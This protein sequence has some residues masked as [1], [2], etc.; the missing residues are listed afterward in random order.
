MPS[1]EQIQVPTV[2]EVETPLAKGMPKE[3]SQKPIRFG[4]VALVIVLASA[5]WYF[6]HAAPPL[7]K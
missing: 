5:V 7:P 2:A 1:E 3:R 6:F 4:L